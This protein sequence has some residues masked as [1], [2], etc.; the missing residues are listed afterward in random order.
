VKHAIF[1]MM[2]AACAPSAVPAPST[3]NSGAFVD[4][5]A[6]VLPTS[7][8]GEAVKGWV[9][10]GKAHTVDLA[11]T[12]LITTTEPFDELLVK[13]VDGEPEIEQ[14]EIQYR[15]RQSR[16]VR[17]E[18]RFAAGEGQVIEL[19]DKRAIE[20][21]VVHTDPDTQGDYVLYGG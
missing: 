7:G 3:A 6:R 19:R 21:I 4:P 11:Q 5:P 14:I 10:L 9:V 2:L 8:G 12:H 15:D 1:A 20:K 17:L 16:T 13:A 18:R